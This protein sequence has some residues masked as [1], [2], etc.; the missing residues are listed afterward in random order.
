MLYL[1]AIVSLYSHRA[2]FRT[3][4]LRCSN[5]FRIFLKRRNFGKL[6]TLCPK[7][8]Q[9]LRPIGPQT[10]IFSSPRF[11]CLKRSGNRY[12]YRRS[13]LCF[14]NITIPNCESNVVIVERSNETEPGSNRELLQK[15]EERTPNQECNDYL[16]LYYG[17]SSTQKYCGNDLSQSLHLLIPTTHFLAIFWTNSADNE[18]GFHLRASCLSA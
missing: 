18:L 13:E 7:D 2:C 14:Y 12:A 11:G 10:R 8:S 15:I 9:A 6:K 17:T 1:V 5:E 3:T 4:V 16:Q